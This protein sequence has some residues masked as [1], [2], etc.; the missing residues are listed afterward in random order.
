MYVRST[1]I[2]CLMLVRLRVTP[3]RKEGGKKTGF[4][5]FLLF[6]KNF[7]VDLVTD[8]SGILGCHCPTDRPVMQGVSESGP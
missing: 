4:C 2:L 8:E 3:E 7:K 6:S 5:Y 1:S